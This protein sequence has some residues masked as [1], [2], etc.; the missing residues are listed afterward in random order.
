MSS[1]GVFLANAGVS[2]TTDGQANRNNCHRG[3]RF[4]LHINGH[5]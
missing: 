1:I 3:L 4:N 5:R 2:A